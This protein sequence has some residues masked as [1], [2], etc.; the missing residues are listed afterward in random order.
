MFSGYEAGA[1]H[2]LNILY[3]FDKNKKLTGAIINVPCP[4]QNSELEH[5]LTADYWNEVRRDLRDKY[6]DIN[7]ISQCAAAGDLSPRILHYKKA[8]ERRYRLKYSELDIDVRVNNKTE[9]YNR[10]EI[11]ERIVSGFDEILSWAKKD[12]I[13]DAKISH[14]VKTVELDRRIISEDEYIYCCDN[15]KRLKQEGFQSTGDIEADFICNS[16]KLSEID[17]LQITVER[18]ELQKEKHT[19]PAEIHIIKIG[20]IAFASNPFELFMDFQH[21]IQ[22]RSPFVQTFIV[23]L[24]AQPSSDS[25]SSVKSAWDSSGY[26]ATERGVEGSGYS[27]TIYCNIVSPGG[28]QQLVE[29]TLEELNALYLL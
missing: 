9:I 2:F 29:K 6:G 26:L 13:F 22:A 7:V 17:R 4:A 28:G 18:Y 21:R 14:S 1:D 24:C 11:A 25:E 5:Y 16:S 12:L 10:Y 15:I 20:D 23:Q 8:Q 27:A 19:I 3:T